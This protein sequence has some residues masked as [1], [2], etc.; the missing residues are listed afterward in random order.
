MKQQIQNVAV[1]KNLKAYDG[2][3]DPIHVLTFDDITV[4]PTQIGLKGSPTNVL[5]S[6]VPVKEKKTELIE[7]I[8]EKEKAAVLTEKLIALKLF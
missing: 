7:G 6:F 1:P 3:E 2:E 4:D 5:R 8:S